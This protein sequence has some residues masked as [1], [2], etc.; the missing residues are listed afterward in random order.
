MI[1]VVPEKPINRVRNQKNKQNLLTGKII[2]RLNTELSNVTV[3]WITDQ[4]TNPP[5]Q[6]V[7]NGA[8]KPWNIANQCGKPLNQGFTWRL[9]SWNS[10]EILDLASLEISDDAKFEFAVT[11]RY[12]PNNENNLW[13]ST[14]KLYNDQQIIEKHLEMMSVYSHLEPPIY[15]RE[16]GS[17]KNPPWF[18]ATRIGSRKLDF[19]QWFGRPCIIVMGFI[20][21]APIP[22]PIS[23]DGKQISESNGVTFVRWIYP[24]P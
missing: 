13:A 7:E 2:N 16:Q 17:K 11:E 4:H 21:D 15:Q 8:I 1:R 12:Q 24:L 19:A 10:N 5:Q 18:Q 20:N 6:Y 9:G 23:I 14:D 3:I 22:A